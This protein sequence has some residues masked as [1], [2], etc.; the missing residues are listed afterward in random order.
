MMI[1]DHV[2]S[3]SNTNS[4]SHKRLYGNRM[5]MFKDHKKW[6]ENT[7]LRVNELCNIASLDAVK[8]AC[9][10]YQLKPCNFWR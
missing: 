8:Y 5:I 10:N 4:I 3:F 6:R 2:P 7:V 9:N 1:C